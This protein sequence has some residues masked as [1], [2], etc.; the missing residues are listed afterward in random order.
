MVE[1]R[2]KPRITSAQLEAASFALR[3]SAAVS[4]LN[5][6]D[7]AKLFMWLIAMEE[8]AKKEKEEEKRQQ[9]L[10]QAREAAVVIA[11]QIEEVRALK[12]AWEKNAHKYSKATRDSVDSYLEYMVQPGHSVSSIT[13]SS[14]PVDAKALAAWAEAQD[15]YRAENPGKEVALDSP[16]KGPAFVNSGFGHRCAAGCSGMHAGVDM[17]PRDGDRTLVAPADGT[18]LA[19]GYNNGGFGNMV[20]IGLDDGRQVLMAHMTGEKMP[21][22]GTRIKQ[23]EQVG[24]MGAT[25]KVTGAHL[26]MEIRVGNQAVQPVVLGMPLVKGSA[27]PGQGTITEASGKTSSEA[28]SVQK[29][30]TV[31]GVELPAKLTALPPATNVAT[32]GAPPP[33]PKMAEATAQKSP[34][35]GAM[36][37]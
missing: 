30:D 25:G 32:N 5:S 35:V 4:H 15:K 1:A 21:A 37:A 24:V 7:K 11:K 13:I 17:L 19:S 29:A 31:T 16:F 12:E 20:L 9:A 36:L 14:R 22:V 3:T 2:T 23:G 33:T 26:H 34:P 18:I 8:E 28:P 6:S 27:V 10:E